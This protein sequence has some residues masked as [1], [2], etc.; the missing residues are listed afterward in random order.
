METIYLTHGSCILKMIIKQASINLIEHYRK[1]Q[2]NDMGKIMQIDELWMSV[3]EMIEIKDLF[4]I[5]KR[6]NRKTLSIIESEIFYN[7]IIARDFSLLSKQSIQVVINNENLNNLD[8]FKFIYCTLRT[9]LGVQLQHLSYARGFINDRIFSTNNQ[10][11]KSSILDCKHV[12]LREQS[13]ISNHNNNHTF[14]CPQCGLVLRTISFHPRDTV[15]R[16]SGGEVF[17]WISPSF[18]YY[19]ENTL[20]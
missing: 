6:V 4:L 18:E 14:N 16:T 12:K 5:M 10:S 2:A 15:C 3:L 13:M 19:L 7:I 11:I 1:M 9:L 8:K 17:Y 20:K